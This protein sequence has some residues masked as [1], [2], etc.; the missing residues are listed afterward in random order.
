MADGKGFS[1]A[2]LRAALTGMVL[3]A[4]GGAIAAPGDPL[5]PPKRPTAVAAHA[6]E[7][8][9]LARAATGAHA[10]AWFDHIDDLSQRALWARAYAADGS[11]RGAAFEVDPGRQGLQRSP[12]LATDGQ[13]RFLVTW[14]DDSGLVGR[15]FADDG[16]PM[17]DRFSIATFATGLI[18]DYGLAMAPDGRFV[19]LTQRPLT[20]SGA[21]PLGLF[22]FLLELRPCLLTV[23]RFDA[24]GSRRGLAIPV[25]T[26][27]D[28]S[29][30]LPLGIPTTL[31]PSVITR[32]QTSSVD[33]GIAADG[34]FVVTWSDYAQAG[35]TPGYYGNGPDYAP[36]KAEI[37][38][39]RYSAA[40][41][42]K[43]A[44]IRVDTISGLPGPGLRRWDSAPVIAAGPGGD[45]LVAWKRPDERLMARRYDAGG[46]AQ[47]AAAEVAAGA[48]TTPA[49][50][51]ASLAADGR[52]IV[53]WA[54]RVPPG[55]SYLNSKVLARMLNPDASPAGAILFADNADPSAGESDPQAASDAQG[56]FVLGWQG[57][58]QT[59]PA[60]YEATV[61]LRRFSG[62]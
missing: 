45:F 11:P 26:R 7:G 34:G 51:D 55:P 46:A 25:A 12:R 18:D 33:L 1:G 6:Q 10:A 20:Q 61:W 15:R 35:V 21:I 41:F 36:L 16:A 22:G 5:G 39:R 8:L 28:S 60:Q 17:G 57:L 48:I 29:L 43:G 59:G 24:D 32:Q 44:L 38:A 53:T 19:V 27:L 42:A 49:E 13:G 56:N 47:A 40:G 3:L 37:L 14:I 23:Q 62:L 54:Q 4:G 9:L 52:G 58:R 30:D 50:I 31:P 2:A